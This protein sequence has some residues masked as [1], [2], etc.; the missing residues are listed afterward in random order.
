MSADDLERRIR[1]AARAA[2]PAFGVSA[3]SRLTLLASTH[4]YVYRVADGRHRFTL[5]VQ[6]SERLTDDLV[7]LQR[8]W[9]RAL[10]RNQSLCIPSPI[11]TTRREPWASIAISGEPSPWRGVL[12]EWVEGSRLGGRRFVAPRVLKDV[13]ATVARMHRASE[14]FA[15]PRASACREIDADALVGSRSCLKRTAARLLRKRDLDSLRESAVRVDEVLSSVPKSRKHYGVIHAD[16]EPAN[17]VFHD[18]QPRPIDF[19]ELGRGYYLFDLL[20]VLWT[21][22]GWD[23]YP[24]YREHLFEG[25]EQVRPLPA[26]TRRHADVFQAATF[27]TWLN[28]GCRLTDAAARR[29]FVKWIPMTSKLVQRLCSA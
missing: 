26:S 17:W 5:R 7:A 21:H 1:S 29:E 12:L 14:Q 11:S 2:L 16:L 18:S 27:Y 3:D 13:G 23:D 20:N 6:H 4:N 15:I 25:Y 22:A 19:D 28:H 24:S 9:L 10:A 8:R